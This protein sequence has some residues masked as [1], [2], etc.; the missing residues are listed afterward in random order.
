MAKDH[1]LLRSGGMVPVDKFGIC[2]QEF[3]GLID[4]NPS[5]TVMVLVL[6]CPFAAFQPTIN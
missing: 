3:A 1:Q 6:G 2:H 5:E 4:A